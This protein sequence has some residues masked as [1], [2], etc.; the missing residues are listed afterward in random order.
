MHYV[1]KLEERLQEMHQLMQ[2]FTDVASICLCSVKLA[3]L[4]VQ[5]L[6]NNYTDAI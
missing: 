6:C 5:P 3:I 4:S 1:Y 2:E